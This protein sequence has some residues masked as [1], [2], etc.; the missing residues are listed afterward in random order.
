MPLA[1]AVTV[2]E[3]GFHFLPCRLEQPYGTGLQQVK[4]GL[5]APVHRAPNVFIP[6]AL[7]ERATSETSQIDSWKIQILQKE[8][9][10]PAFS[11]WMKTI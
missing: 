5:G 4:A 2:R 1:P 7:W 8:G 11:R 10:G 6:H 3:S 9:R